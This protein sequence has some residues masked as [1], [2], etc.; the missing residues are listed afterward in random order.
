MILHGPATIEAYNNQGFWGEKTLLDLFFEAADAHLENLALADPLDRETLVGSPPKRLTYRELQDRVLGMATALLRMGL[1]KDDVVV[2]QLPNVWELPM[3]FLAVAKA[4]GVLSPMPVQWRENEL[5]YVLG[6]TEA[7]LY[8][9]PKRFKGVDF[10]AMARGLYR[11]GLQVLDLE[12]IEPLS[13]TEPDPGLLSSTRVLADDIFSLCWTSGTEA[14]PK[15]CPLSHN[16]WIYQ[17]NM[18][19]RVGG[20]KDGDSQLVVAP[21][22]NM[23]GVGVNFIPWLLSQG[24]LFMHH[25]IDVPLLLRQLTEERISFTILVP[26]VLNMILKLPDADRLDLSSVRTITTGSA[27]P[28]KW[29]LEEF[30]RRWG[31]E[32]VNIWG[33]NEGTG[34]VAG[35]VDVPDLALRT[36][37]FPNWGNPACN[38]RSGVRGVSLK[39]L[40]ESLKP[41]EASGAVGELAYK[42]PNVFP[43]Y[44]KRPDLTKRAFTD[45]GYF[46]T[47]DLFILW[48]ACHVGFFDRKKDIIIRGG[49]NISAA[50]VENLLLGHP[51]IKEAAC[52]AEP[53]EIL[54]E[55]VLAF[56]VPKDPKNPPSLKAVVNFLKGLGVASYKLPERLESIEAIPRNPVGKILKATLKQ[57]L[58]ERS[59]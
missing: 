19:R 44:F 51:D 12:E 22:V 17:G 54:G 32:I 55:R 29:T 24:T 13:R 7:P 35:P 31:I 56:V 23:T 27:Q 3:L 59:T 42:G 5:R 10:T 46:L 4:G 6:L 52:V 18:L 57:R 34:L 49:F 9:G 50:E 15:G 14:E 45:D 8:I 40:D 2:C 47:G 36:D 38:F 30:K 39:L 16:N 48:D 28:S 33:Q 26:A 25:P 41:L 58:I 20:L 53:H 1:Q 21:M 37:H 43:G 11:G